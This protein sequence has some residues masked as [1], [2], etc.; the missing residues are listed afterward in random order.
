[1]T[2]DMGKLMVVRTIVSVCALAV[3]LAGCSRQQPQQQERR[4]PDTPSSTAVVDTRPVIATFGDSLTSGVVERTYP[5][6]LQQLLDQNGFKYQVENQGV[7]GDTTSDGLARIDNVIAL[8]LNP[9]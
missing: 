9:S 6:Y 5:Q 3:A 2:F 7:A 4:N 1:M 8:K